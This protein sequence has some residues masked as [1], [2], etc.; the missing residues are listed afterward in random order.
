MK[1]GVRSAK[2]GVRLALL[3]LL[4]FAAAP[5]AGWAQGERKDERSAWEHSIVT[6]EVARKQV[7]TII[8]PGAKARGGCKRRGWSQGSGRC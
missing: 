2:C 3:L 4:A 8:N 7:P 5:S 1:C 6:L